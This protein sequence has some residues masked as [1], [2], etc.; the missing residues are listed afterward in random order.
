MLDNRTNK[1]LIVS[2]KDGKTEKEQ[3]A[4]LTSPMENKRECC[5]N[6]DLNSVLNMRK[7]VDHFINTGT[8]L[9]AFKRLR[10][11]TLEEKNLA[12]T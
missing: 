10:K 6:R 1:N 12:E 3:H 11:E 9:E 2:D 4:V 7:I 5:I 8:R